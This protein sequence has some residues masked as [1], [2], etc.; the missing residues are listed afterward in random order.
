MISMDKK[1]S[2][3]KNTEFYVALVM[4]LFDGILIWQ[5]LTI[6]HADSRMLP[7]F[8]CLIVTA[9]AAAQLHQVLKNREKGGDI[10]SVLL[11]K[12][13][14]GVFLMLLLSWCIY[15]VLGFYT[16][17][18]LLLVGVTLLVQAPLTPKKI[19]ASLIY[20]VVLMI[21]VYICFA[22]LLGMVTPTGLII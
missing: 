21:L 18:F 5:I 2:L 22:I 3:W 16:T 9:S 1:A 10:K 8:T 19:A 11:K 7:I 12:K 4:F 15:D 13:E 6:H 20:D 17:V 14:L